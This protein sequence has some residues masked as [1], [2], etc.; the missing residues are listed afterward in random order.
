MTVLGATVDDMPRSE[1]GVGLHRTRADPRRDGRLQNNGY[2]R[3]DIQSKG[4]RDEFS[5]PITIRRTY[6]TRGGGSVP[7]LRY[8]S[9]Y[10]HQRFNEIVLE[11][12]R[13]VFGMHSFSDRL[14]T[15]DTR[16]IQA[17]ILAAVYQAS[18]SSGE[19]TRSD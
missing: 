6:A 1:P 2:A 4:N 7:D 13:T 3:H 10:V 15:E 17:F 9:E 5:Q 14:T 16:K 8:A 19:E 12:E 11:G 18:V